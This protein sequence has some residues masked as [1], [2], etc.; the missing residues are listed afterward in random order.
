MLTNYNVGRHIYKLVY[1]PHYKC[2]S[3]CNFLHHLSYRSGPHFV[4]PPRM[5]QH[6]PTDP[7]Q[8]TDSPHRPWHRWPAAPVHASW[9]TLWWWNLSCCGNPKSIENSCV[10][11]CTAILMRCW[12][13]YLFGASYNVGNPILNTPSLK[14]SFWWVL[15]GLFA[16]SKG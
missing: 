11:M 2:H 5:A 14:S 8:E 4:L 9:L 10:I 3:H 6:Q 12:C 1:K 15:C 7:S 16:I 13:F